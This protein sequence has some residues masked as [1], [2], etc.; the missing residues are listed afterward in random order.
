[1]PTA[2]VCNKPIDITHSVSIVQCKSVANDNIEKRDSVVSSVMSNSV[3]CCH[4]LLYKSSNFTLDEMGGNQI[5][6]LKMATLVVSV[7]VALH[8]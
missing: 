5:I 1:M 3:Q 8:Y 2:K 6:I 4:I 7:S